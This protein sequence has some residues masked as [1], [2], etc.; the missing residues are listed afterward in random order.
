MADIREIE[1]F[2]KKHQLV[3]IEDLA[4]SVGRFY[5]DGREAGQVGEIVVF[6]FGKEKSIDVVNGGAVGFRNPEMGAVPTPQD[7]PPR[8]EVKRARM[9]PTYGLWY[10]R[11]SYLGM[12]GLLMRFLLSTG[13]VVRSAE[14]EIDWQ[15]RGLSDWQAKLALAKL[16][17]RAELRGQPLRE[18]YLVRERETVLRRLRQAGYYFDGV[19]YDKP[20]GPARYYAEVK[21]P[22]AECPVAVEVAAK[23]V[24]LPNYYSK[25]ELK[26]AREII[27]EYVD[28]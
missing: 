14:G 19:W 20:V 22:E 15:T 9:Y 7:A 5:A 27:E 10:R 16:K 24:N 17:K 8:E 25:Q 12:H 21:Y 18:F 11:L 6:S 23:I 3:L 26:R 28:E 4:H 13:R 2:C 1:A